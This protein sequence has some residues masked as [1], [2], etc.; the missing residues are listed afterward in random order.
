MTGQQLRELTPPRVNQWRPMSERL[1]AAGC[2]TFGR[3][4][5]RLTW[6]A[7][8]IIGVFFDEAGTGW[9]ATQEHCDKN[10]EFKGFYKEMTW[11]GRAPMPS[12][13]PME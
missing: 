4:S 7:N 10:D 1:R 13:S 11:N 8:G 6:S 12:L 5:H 3:S 9:Y 2:K